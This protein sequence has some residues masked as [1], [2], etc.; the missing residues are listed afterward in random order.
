M[1]IGTHM[2]YLHIANTEQRAYIGWINKKQNPF[3]TG[4]PNN[5]IAINPIFDGKVEINKI[6]KHFFIKVL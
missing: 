1:E 2:L 5:F 3:K 4:V 6:F